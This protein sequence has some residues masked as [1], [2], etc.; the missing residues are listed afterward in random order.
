MLLR[1]WITLV[2]TVNIFEF[3]YI[4]PIYFCTFIYSQ[5]LSKY[6]FLIYIN[7]A[8][9]YMKNKNSIENTDEIIPL[10]AQHRRQSS[11]ND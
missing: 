8:N 7:N 3:I 6:G 9:I 2:V 11:V 5:H 10:F 4:S 1:L